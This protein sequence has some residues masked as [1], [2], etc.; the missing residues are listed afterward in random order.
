MA[1][2]RPLRAL[3][4]ATLSLAVEASDVGAIYAL[5]ALPDTPTDVRRR[6]QV[7]AGIL[8]ATRQAPTLAGRQALLT[9]GDLTAQSTIEGLLADLD[10]VPEPV[11]GV[12]KGYSTV[13]IG[14]DHVTFR[15][16]RQ[17]TDADFA[18]GEWVLQQLCGPDNTSDYKGIGFVS[19]K[20]GHGTVRLWRRHQADERLQ[21]AVAALA[22]DPLAAGLAWAQEHEHCCRCGRRISAGDSLKRFLER[23]GLGPDCFKVGN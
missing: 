1:S 18:P 11:T 15:V 12:R 14:D 19:V 20:E 16:R 8:G 17:P 7:R 6:A 3:R 21:L 9:T 23:G 4:I 10:G 13:H 5:A 22:G 2:P